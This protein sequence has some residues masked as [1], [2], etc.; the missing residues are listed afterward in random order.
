MGLSQRT[1]ILNDYGF[2]ATNIM[3]E[4]CPHNIIVHH[5]YTD[6]ASEPPK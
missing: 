1:Y 2:E 4:L 6:P 3:I 5:Q